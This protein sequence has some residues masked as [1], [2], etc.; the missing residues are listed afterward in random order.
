[1]RIS[2]QVP[3]E[4]SEIPRRSAL[5]HIRAAYRQAETPQRGLQQRQ[6]CDTRD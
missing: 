2:N 4:V 3:G 5:K 1:M 6:G